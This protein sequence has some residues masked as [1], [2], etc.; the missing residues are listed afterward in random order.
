MGTYD[1]KFHFKW[2]LIN[3]GLFWGLFL[4][5]PSLL[6]SALGLEIPIILDLPFH[7]LI[8]LGIDSTLSYYYKEK[9][10]KKFAKILSLGILYALVLYVITANSL[11]TF[12]LSSLSL[13]EIIFNPLYG[14]IFAILG[15]VGYIIQ[16]VFGIYRFIRFVKG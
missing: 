4:F 14:E 8:H 9:K 3:L 16:F 7:S 5:P 1:R 11:V 2:Y 15:V 10:N 12:I 6:L 13:Q